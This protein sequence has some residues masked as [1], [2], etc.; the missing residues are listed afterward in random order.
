MRCDR[1]F[2][3]EE[4]RAE[5]LTMP[6]NGCMSQSNE[7]FKQSNNGSS[8]SSPK[9]RR[10]IRPCGGLRLRLQRLPLTGLRSSSSGRRQVRMLL[11]LHLRLLLWGC[12]RHRL[13][14][15]LQ[16]QHMLRVVLRRRIHTS[17]GLRLPNVRLQQRVCVRKRHVRR[18]VP[19]GR[20]SRRTRHRR[21]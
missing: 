2:N 17:G 5:D 16:W 8:N 20:R 10:S 18:H 12:P 4:Q 6:S 15:S 11:L 3:S 21:R 9:H 19:Q 13:R 7:H 14:E 1:E